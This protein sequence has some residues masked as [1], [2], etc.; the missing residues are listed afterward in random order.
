[1]LTD[2]PQD[3]QQ[4]HRGQQLSYLSK[5]SGIIRTARMIPPS[6][7]THVTNIEQRS[8]AAIVKTTTDG[9]VTVDLPS[10]ENLVPNGWYML[11]VNSDKGTPSYAK[12]IQVV[13]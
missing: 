3:T 4:V 2:E 1:M 7:A 13:D 6:T 11:F 12:M 5:N 8:I 9:R 10:D